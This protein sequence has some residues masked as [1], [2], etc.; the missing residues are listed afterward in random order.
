MTSYHE[1]QQQ[2]NIPHSLTET[3]QLRRE[4]ERS[5]TEPEGDWYK[6]DYVRYWEVVL[7]CWAV[8][9]CTSTFTFTTHTTVPV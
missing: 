9:A 6:T 5:V 4:L 2:S 7:P 1:E 8:R 3:V